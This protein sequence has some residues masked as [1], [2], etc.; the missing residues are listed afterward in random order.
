[1]RLLRFLSRVAFICNVS[2]V[3]TSLAQY[4]PHLQDGTI[5][6]TIV[7]MGYLMSIV[8]NILVN[9]S[10]LVVWA[11]RKRAMEIPLWLVIVNFIFFV[12][13][14]LILFLNTHDPRHT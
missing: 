6:S 7:V 4:V 8:V 3:L 10:L 11:F 1:M 5:L 12:V 13:Q 9:L 14:L 2:F